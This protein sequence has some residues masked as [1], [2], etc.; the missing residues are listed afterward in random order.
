MEE[1][2]NVSERA[3]ILLGYLLVS[4]SILF[5]QTA[6]YRFSSTIR[7]PN[8]GQHFVS[9]WLRAFVA[10]V[11]IL[12]T[13]AA[14]GCA[15]APVLRGTAPTATPAPSIRVQPSPS[16]PATAD[17]A[18]PTASSEQRVIT[19]TVWIPGTFNGQDA[20]TEFLALQSSSDEFQAEH[21]NLR[22]RYARKAVSG[23]AGLVSFLRSAREVA[24]STLP[25][26]VVLPTD[27]VQASIQNGLLYPLDNTLSPETVQDMYGFATA[28]V[29]NGKLLAVGLAVD[30]EHLAFDPAVVDRVPTTWQDILEQNQSFLFPAAGEDGQLNDATMIQYLAAGGQLINATGEASLN[31]DSL[32]QVFNFYAHALALGI[33]PSSTLQIGTSDESWKAYLT[34]GAAMTTVG[35]RRFLQDGLQRETTSFSALPTLNGRT[36]ALARGWSIGLVTDDSERREAV[37][38]YLAWLLNPGVLGQWCQQLGHLPATRSALTPAVPNDEYRAFLSEQLEAAGVRPSSVAAAKASAAAQ[39][40]LQDLLQ[41]KLAPAAA[42]EAALNSL[43]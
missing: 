6:K 33:V 17:T 32:T 39:R 22:I 42:V 12:V 36:V 34:G 41:K 26:L 13:A 15:R 9:K 37:S 3:I 21:E 28:S 30:I 27:R 16:V 43:G 23:P 35:S 1:S 18:V 2:V 31:K 38:Q 25:D 4:R 11:P 7:G 5:S 40:A 8:S 19:L 10:G 29:V 14:V 20:E 24:P